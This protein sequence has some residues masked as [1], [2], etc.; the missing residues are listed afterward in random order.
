MIQINAKQ[1]DYILPAIA[2]TATLEKFIPAINKVLID[3]GLDTKERVAAF[4]AQLGHESGE[5]QYM[6][7]NL[8]YSAA[9]LRKTFPKYF[10]SVAA[11]E[12][13]ARQ[14]VK[15]ASRVYANRMG[16]GDEASR[17]GW[18]FKGRGLIQVTGRSNYTTL[19]KC[20]GKSLTDTIAYLETVEGA[21][22]SAGWFWKANN[23]RDLEQMNEFVLLTR[24]IN[25]G[26]NGLEHRTTLYKRALAIL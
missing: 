17:D 26:T 8:N 2:G 22:V 25:G 11:A 14:P 3:Q 19:A 13:Y 9:G 21:V 12:A 15:I 5:F 6:A 20:V 23:L 16:N 18:T 4:L 1:L 10:A 24:K 7:E